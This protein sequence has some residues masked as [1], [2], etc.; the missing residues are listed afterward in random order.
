M[1]YLKLIQSP[2]DLEQLISLLNRARDARDKIQNCRLVQ[3]P[4]SPDLS[5]WSK[6]IASSDSCVVGLFDG[7]KLVGVTIG[8]ITENLWD[9]KR[10]GRIIAWFVD[11]E[12]RG[13]KAVRMLQTVMNWF[14][15]RSVEYVVANSD[16][17]TTSHKAYTRLG[18]KPLE[19]V[20]YFRGGN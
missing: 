6:L 4:W 3:K 18:F 15:Y 16:F 5:K 10:I 19:I 17:N 7:D 13:I 2:D 8:A 14:K 20:L 1:S 12:Y 9:D 11:D